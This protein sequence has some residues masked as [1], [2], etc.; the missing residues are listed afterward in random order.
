MLPFMIHKFGLG[1]IVIDGMTSIFANFCK[2]NRTLSLDPKLDHI[3][4]KMKIDLLL[5]RV[6]TL[7]FASILISL[8]VYQ[9]QFITIYVSNEV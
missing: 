7:V 6:T 2:F 5:E 8:D 3:L 4:T 9:L 1:Y